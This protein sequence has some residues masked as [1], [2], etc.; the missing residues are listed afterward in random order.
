MV[1]VGESRAPV[2]V[3]MNESQW[4]LEESVPAGTHV[5]QIS[6]EAVHKTMQVALRCE[7]VAF[8]SDA[9]QVRCF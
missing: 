6:G 2:Y 3:H 8:I 1:R 5:G 7:F 4:K 9:D